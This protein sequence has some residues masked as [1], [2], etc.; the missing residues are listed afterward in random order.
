MTEEENRVIDIFEE[1]LK[2]LIDLAKS[3]E[4]QNQE[5]LTTIAAKDEEIA[6]LKDKLASTETDYQNLKL[7]KVLSVS[8]YDLDSTKKKVSGLVREI[9]HCIEL[10]NGSL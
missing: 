2:R 10:L 5:L 8:G 7:S 1:K 6:G 4:N 3:L 9:D